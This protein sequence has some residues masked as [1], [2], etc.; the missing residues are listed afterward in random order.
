MARGLSRTGRA[1]EQRVLTVAP[2]RAPDR[3]RVVVTGMGMITP[4]G[5]KVRE[6]VARASQSCSGIDYIRGFDTRGLPVRI[7]GRGADQWIRR[8]QGGPAAKLEKMAS[9]AVRFMWTAATE[10][11]EQ[12]KLDRIRDRYRIGVALGYHGETAS[13]EE[14]ARMFRAWDGDGQWEP[15]RL[16]QGGYDAFAVVRGEVDLGPSRFPLRVA[17]RGPSAG[18]SSA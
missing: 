1:D 12:A 18:M 6:T 9:R 13:L 2:R 11:V 16:R 7:G 5:P 14:L 4:R 15:M 3:R 17:V 8:R 10:A